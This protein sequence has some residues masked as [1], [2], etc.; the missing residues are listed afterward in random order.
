LLKELQKYVQHLKG[1]G[2]FLASLFLLGLLASAAS[3]ATPLIGKFF[4]DAVAERH[5]YSMVPK[6]AGALVVIAVFDILLATASRLIHARLSADVLVSIRQRLFGHCLNSPLAELEKF[7]HGD[8]MSRFGGDISK[9]QSLLVDGVLGCLQN[10]IFLMVA[11]V[12]L[13]TMSMPL[14]IWS[15]L[16]VGIALL[17]TMAFRRPVETGSQGIRESMADLSH[18]LSERLAALRAVRIHGA[19]KQDE[20]EF[21]DL[22]NSLVSKLL[23]FQVLESFSSGL[24][25]LALTAS[26]AWIYFLGGGLL[27]SG[28]IGLGTFVAFVLYQGR[29]FGPAQGLLG[30]VRNLQEA[31]ISLARVAELLQNE[32]H[33][34]GGAVQETNGSGTLVFEKV[35]F[36]YPGK[37]P[38]LNQLDLQVACGER[39]AVF[40]SSGVGKS[41]LVQILFGLRNATSG[42]VFVGGVRLDSGSARLAGNVLGYAGNEPFLL[43][44][45]VEENLRYG[46]STVSKDAL[47][48]AARLADAEGFILSMPEG[49]RTVI[50]GR[51]LS[52]SDG[53]RQR[54]GLARLFLKKPD[55]LVLDEAFSSLDPDTETR[56]RNNLF[57]SFPKQTILVITHRL[58]GLDQFDRLMLFADGQLT[59]VTAEELREAL[60]GELFRA[61]AP[62]S[63]KPDSSLSL[64]D[65]AKG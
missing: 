22:N 24:P 25:G 56:V 53:Q 58:G 42:K 14:A 34:P 10:L 44:A 16:G 39:V 31:K 64:P 37:P 38:V 32:S 36:S 29:L 27:E 18:F 59:Q 21:A 61:V 60:T 40:G 30:L 6:I 65:R 46:N 63:I 47:C 28:A 23:R 2:L 11:A 43:H 33:L 50:G 20:A 5:D 41:T 12:I 51:G 26:L 55:V 4:I 9:I 15:F 45:S 1:K 19:Q 17:I 49:Y 57:E 52:L 62:V 48:E 13:V 3:L 7:R 54:L 8:L 35:S